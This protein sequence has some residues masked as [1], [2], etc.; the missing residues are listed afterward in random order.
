[1]QKWSRGTSL[2]APQRKIGTRRTFAPRN[3]QRMALAQCSLMRSKHK[4]TKNK[5]N[6]ICIMNTKIET[7]SDHGNFGAIITEF[8]IVVGM[9]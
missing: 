3:P 4:Q 1:V 2:A 8:G 6:N 7:G 9:T 5:C